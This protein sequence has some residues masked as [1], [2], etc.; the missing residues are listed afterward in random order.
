ML[1]PDWKNESHFSVSVEPQLLPVGCKY[2]CFKIYS[3]FFPWLKL[4]TYFP[5]KLFFGVFG[6]WSS[7]WVWEYF[8]EITA[9]A[10]SKSTVTLNAKMAFDITNKGLVFNIQLLAFGNQEKAFNVFFFANDCVCSLGEH[11]AHSKSNWAS[12]TRTVNV[13]FLWV[14]SLI[15]LTLHV[16]ST[17][18]LH[19]TH[20]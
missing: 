7:F 15:F 10:I 14:A 5:T 19:W 4:N 6:C 1:Y 11:L 12:F 9:S 8:R 16:N 3:K 13:T 18:G 17:I 20:F 2:H